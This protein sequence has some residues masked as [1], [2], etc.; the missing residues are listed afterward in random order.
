M[1]KYPKSDFLP[2]S[3]SDHFHVSV[4]KPNLIF[5]YLDHL[6]MTAVRTAR[7]EFMCF[8]VFFYVSLLCACY[9]S[10]SFRLTACKQSRATAA[11]GVSGEMRKIQFIE[12]LLVKPNWKEL[13]GAECKHCHVIHKHGS[14][15]HQ[16]AL[17]L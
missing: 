1:L 8:F 6:L 3:E 16:I 14:C 10:S 7:S 4:N 17:L 12:K 9:L 11:S 15:H 2:P 13:I 5:S